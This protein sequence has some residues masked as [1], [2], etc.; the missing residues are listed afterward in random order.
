MLD[1]LQEQNKITVIIISLS[2]IHSKTYSYFGKNSRDCSF[3]L[4][5]PHRAFEDL[6]VGLDQTWT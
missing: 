2:S 1:L 5:S 6:I 3:P 4:N